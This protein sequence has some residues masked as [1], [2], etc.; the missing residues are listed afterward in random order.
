MQIRQNEHPSHHLL[1]VH[2]WFRSL[3]NRDSN[4]ATHTDQ[5]GLR[6]TFYEQVQHDAFTCPWP[7]CKIDWPGC[8]N[9]KVY[10]P[11]FQHT[12]NPTLDTCRKI[13]TSFAAPNSNG[14]SPPAVG[15]IRAA[16]S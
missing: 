6:C 13:G 14:R 2:A 16:A 11:T 4:I 9:R 12:R 8:T 3:D 1:F 10:I 5:P 7:G 15:S